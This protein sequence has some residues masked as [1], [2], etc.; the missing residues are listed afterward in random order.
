MKLK[1]KKRPV[2]KQVMA[3]DGKRWVF[4][5]SAAGLS[6]IGRVRDNPGIIAFATAVRADKV[7]DGNL[8]VVR[9]DFAQVQ[10]TGIHHNW[11]WPIHEDAKYIVLVW[12]FHAPKTWQIVGYIMR[13]KALTYPQNDE[14]GYVI[15]WSEFES[16]IMKQ[17]QPYNPSSLYEAP[18]PAN[19]G[20]LQE[21]ASN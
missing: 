9:G 21:A 8:A 12:P 6:Q 18:P 14:G 3:H 17:P 5:L 13:D 16:F 1:Y 2:D 20:R 15:P 4:E 7:V 19:N 11:I 10:T